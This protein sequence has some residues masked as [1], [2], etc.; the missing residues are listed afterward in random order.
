MKEYSNRRFHLALKDILEKNNVKLRGLA[1]RTNL[2]YTY[3][4]KLKNRKTSP[5]IKTME[6]IARGLGIEPEYFLEY[7]INKVAEF[8]ILNPEY[9]RPVI[10]Y[11]EQL[12]NKKK[13]KVAEPGESFKEK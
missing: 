1:G 6:I 5:P 10:S 12:K 9:V 13:L 7:R 11:I 8:L 2:N 4:S 3:F